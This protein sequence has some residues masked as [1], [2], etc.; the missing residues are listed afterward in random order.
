MQGWRGAWIEGSADRAARA[1]AAFADYPV[2]VVGRYIT[3]ENADALIA[4]LSKGEELDLLS[5][6]ID[7][8]DYWVWQAIKTV[9]PRL[10]VIEYNATW[11]PFFCKTVAQDSVKGWQGDNFYGASLGAL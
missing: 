7:S 6:D 11:P 5:I 2:E 9:K 10:V 8:V 1:T 3:V 4:E